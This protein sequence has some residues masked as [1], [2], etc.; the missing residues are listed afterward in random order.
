MKKIAMISDHASPL[1][2]IG[3]INDGGQNIYVKNIAKKMGQRGYQVDIF[4]R[5]DNPALKSSVFLSP[6]V[7][8]IHVPAGPPNYVE[9]EKLLPYMNEFTDFMT[10]YIY[11]NGIYD[12][13]HAN[14]F[15]SGLVAMKLKDYFRIPFFITFH[16]L[17]RVRRHFQRSEDKF[18]DIRFSIE[19]DI[20]SAADGIIAECP[21]DKQD[22]I[23]YYSADHSKIVV[24][25]CGVDFSELHPIDQRKARGCLGLQDDEKII[26]QLGRL[27]PR[28]GIETIIHSLKILH[29]KYHT[30]ARLLIVG[31]ST[32][33]PDP[34]ETPEIDR[35]GKI[36]RDAGLFDKVIFCGRASREEIKIYYNAADVFVTTPWY[37]PFGIT[38]LEA[39]ACQKPVI[40]SRVGG[41]QFTIQHGR[42]G[43]LVPPRD[44]YS[45]AESIK[46]L[47]ANPK[48]GKIFGRNGRQR[49]K[50]NFTWETVV[51]ALDQS[52]NKRLNHS[53]YVMKPEQGPSFL[54]NKKIFSIEEV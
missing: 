23:D 42:T 33:R 38:P 14:F 53:V 21:Q 51:D 28:K 4:T 29:K 10:D 34:V 16:A 11:K 24:I 44:P 43:F 47:F 22:L 30:S 46:E 15:M 18:S 31:G 17:G 52:I 8:V 12:F 7:R 49:V 9:K 2:K 25:P 54:I 1:A 26:L 32:K 13:I 50:K 5:R 19:D 41:L 37:E 39:M 6:R 48:L 3:S 40:G 45:L 27:V 20:V 35:L 36:A